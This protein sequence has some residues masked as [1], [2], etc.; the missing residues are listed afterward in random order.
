MEQGRGSARSRSRVRFGAVS[1]VALGA[2]LLAGCVK[3]APPPPPPNPPLVE[4]YTL[5]PNPVALG[6]ISLGTPPLP[7]PEATVTVRNDG[8]LV[9]TPTVAVTGD[10]HFFL[11]PGA[12][13]T[14]GQIVNG[15]T[16]WNQLQPGQACVVTVAYT[17]NPAVPGP[18]PTGPIAGSVQVLGAPSGPSHSL[19]GPFTTRITAN[20]TP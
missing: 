5:T 7:A 6:D 8:G 2:V 19:A 20:L 10:A 11:D 16:T 4:H 18:F 12:Q 3:P 9:G 13:F 1:L 17:P 14:C 15:V